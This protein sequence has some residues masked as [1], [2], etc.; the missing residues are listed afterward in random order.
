[1]IGVH[2]P[3]FAFEKNIKNVK[4]AIGDLNVEFPV[5]IDNNFTIWRAFKNNYWPANYFIDA[6]GRVRFHHFGEGE[7]EKSEQVIQ[8][9]LEEA[10]KSSSLL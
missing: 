5:A 6:Q 4:R 7:Y 1:M 3:E 8:Q 10:K 2:A 9:L